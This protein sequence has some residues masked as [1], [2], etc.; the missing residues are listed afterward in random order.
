MREIKTGM[1]WLYVSASS[2]GS[3]MMPQA[4]DYKDNDNRIMTKLTS[5]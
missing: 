4:D 1:Q 5:I 3:A 2:V